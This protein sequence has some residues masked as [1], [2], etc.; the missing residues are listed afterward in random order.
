MPSS[1]GVPQQ[2]VDPLAPIEQ[3]AGWI[4]STTV[5]VL[6]GLFIGMVAARILRQRQVRWSWAACAV[7]PITLCLLYTSRCV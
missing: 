1:E 7:G 3:A 6:L 2:G 4:A 5:H